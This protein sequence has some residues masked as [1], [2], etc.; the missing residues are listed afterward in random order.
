MALAVHDD[1]VF[2]PA[3]EQARL[4][5][6]KQLSAVELTEL[7][8][9]R[10]ERLNPVLNAFITVTA[11]HA[12]E[13]ARA[14]DAKLGDDNLPP[15]HGLPIGIK[16]LSATAGIRTTYGTATRSE[17][18]PDADDE[19]VTRIKRAGFSIIGKTNTPEFGLLNITE[20]PAYGPCR[21]P[22]DT[23]RS[24]GGSSGGSASALAAGLTPIGHGSDAGGSIRVPSS[25]C[26]LFGIKPSRGRVSGAPHPQALVWQGGPI[27]RTVA[28]AAAFLDAISGYST[29]DMW[30]APPP[31]RPFVEEAGRDPGRLRIAFTTKP[32]VEG[33]PVAPGNQRVAEETATL[34]AE[35]GHNVEEASP[36]WDPERL[37]RGP[38]IFAA[39]LAARPDLPALDTLDPFVRA[40][41]EF[42]ALISTS[43]Y[44]R[45]IDETHRMVR[46][47]VAFFD[48]Y[49]IL[50]TPTV[51]SPP[52]KIGE[53]SGF[54]NMIE[55]MPV[56]IGFTPF[57]DA[58]NM[59]GQPAASLPMG[60]DEH[61]L[62]VGAQIVGR[63]ADEAT[64]IRLSAQIEQARP[65]ADR[66]PVVS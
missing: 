17:N 60:M 31:E 64:L 51:A 28:D 14:A 63:P 62:P 7:Y 49:D 16:D 50:L 55:A 26:G 18:V 42:G 54:A 59:T 52:P 43:D 58:W 10:I 1:V 5:K 19:I 53:L 20:P 33:V 41:A 2:A 66:R 15:F 6:E 65:W 12:L 36:K 37:T 40:L 11:D 44:I 48:D 30:W 25:V 24:P 45:A 38:L 21:N 27:A 29:G 32:T 8:L 9:A 47:L 34:L 4:V 39:E 61:G 23:D 13:G 22:W 46:E 3:L 35:L 56:L 57:T